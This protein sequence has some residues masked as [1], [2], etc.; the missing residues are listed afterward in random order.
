M[1]QEAVTRTNAGEI[2][3][4]EAARAA[5]YQRERAAAIR[6]QQRQASQ[7]LA[8]VSPANDEAL[9]PAANDGDEQ[10]SFQQQRQREQ[11]QNIRA[12]QRMGKKDG[13][14][15]SN[16]FESLGGGQDDIKD[17][18]LLSSAVAE[19]W[20]VWPPLALLGSYHVRV[21]GGKPSGSRPVGLEIMN[22]PLGLLNDFLEKTVLPA[23]KELSG[24]I[25]GAAGGAMGAGQA[26]GSGFPDLGTGAGTG[27]ADLGNDRMSGLNAGQILLMLCCDAV[28]LFGL[29]TCSAFLMTILL[30]VGVVGAGVGG[31]I[32]GACSFSPT[33]CDLVQSW[34]GSAFSSLLGS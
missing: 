3:H 2:Q 21:L 26:A 1:A 22:E 30:G 24:A 10:I 6:A 25:G 5:T 33:L 27:I 13:S 18:I 4:I 15:S 12:I 28:L 7:Q 32:G 31:V 11:T 9:P 17:L 20:A 8:A 34:F 19:F 14:L 23:S 29:L 16:V